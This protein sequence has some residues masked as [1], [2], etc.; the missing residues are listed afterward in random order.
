MGF[1]LTAVK[2]QQ[3]IA[4]WR[5]IARTPKSLPPPPPSCQKSLM[6]F[7][8][9]R[10]QLRLVVIDGVGGDTGV[11]SQ[12]RLRHLPTAAPSPHHVFFFFFFFYSN[13]N[14]LVQLEDTTI[15]TERGCSMQRSEGQSRITDQIYFIRWGEWVELTDKKSEVRQTRRWQK[16][17]KTK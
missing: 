15:K 2:Q 14:H 4:V 7:D 5:L 9:E 11:K 13:T 1:F 16:S 6:T 3:N 8:Q 12:H 17:F 10:M